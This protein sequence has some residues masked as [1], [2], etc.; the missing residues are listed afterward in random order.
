MLGNES[1]FL[2]G[3]VLLDENIESV[4]LLNDANYV[5]LS[6]NPVMAI[7]KQLLHFGWLLLSEAVQ[8][9]VEE[10]RSH[11]INIQFDALVGRNVDATMVFKLGVLVLRELLLDL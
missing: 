9:S 2:G 4:E 10:G 11:V 3:Q 7:L 1:L 5:K 8:D 6:V